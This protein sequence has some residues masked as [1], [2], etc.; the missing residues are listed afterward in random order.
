MPSDANIF[1]NPPA[2]EEETPTA[3]NCASIS[4]IGVFFEKTGRV[5]MEETGFILSS[6]LEY[7]LVNKSVCAAKKKLKAF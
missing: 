5:E 2:A 6:S 4:C 1:A 3:T 7:S